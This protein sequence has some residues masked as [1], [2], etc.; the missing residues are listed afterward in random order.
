MLLIYSCNNRK[1]GI[2]KFYVIF[3][4]NGNRKIILKQ[5]DVL[6]I[7]VIHSFIFGLFAVFFQEPVNL[8]YVH[9]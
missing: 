4:H 9:I 6:S 5:K 7:Y 1:N 3:F 2:Q 8:K